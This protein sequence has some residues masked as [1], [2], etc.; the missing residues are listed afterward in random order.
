[1]K[2]KVLTLNSLSHFISFACFA[3]CIAMP[4]IILAGPYFS[5]FFESIWI[6][7]LILLFSIL[8]GVFIIYS[9]YCRHKR[10]HSS[11]LFSFGCLL[12]I[13][14]SITHFFHL[15]FHYLETIFL[16]LGALFVIISYYL[17][18]K[19]LKCCSH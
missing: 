4:F 6:E 15:H 3:H 19:L 5:Q 16:V 18:H 10:L 1:M 14:H 17:N 12:W 2:S 9:G 8:C 11:V 7:L 13:G